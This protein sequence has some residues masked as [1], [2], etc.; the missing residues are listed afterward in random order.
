MTLNDTFNNSIYLTEIFRSHVLDESSVPLN[1]PPY[2]NNDFFQTIKD[3]INLG[4]NV[5][6]FSTKQWYNF[7]IQKDYMYATDED[8]LNFSYY[9]SK[10]EN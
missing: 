5:S 7:L 2:Y 6:T 4:M 1:C 9:P 8:S 10:I 3:A